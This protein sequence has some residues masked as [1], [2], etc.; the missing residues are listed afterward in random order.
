MTKKIMY[1]L[2]DYP[3]QT[4]DLGDVLFCVLSCGVDEL[5]MGCILAK[6][7]NFGRINVVSTWRGP[8]SSQYVCNA[9]ASF[10]LID[11][12]QLYIN[13]GLGLHVREVTRER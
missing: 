2:T 8:Y 10:L 1:P 4:I 3:F 13:V 6:E 7:L 12:L 9:L 11:V 5:D